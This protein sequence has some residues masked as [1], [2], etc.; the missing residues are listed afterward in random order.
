MRLLINGYVPLKVIKSSIFRH[1]FSSE[2]KKEIS[3][4]LDYHLFGNEGT[5]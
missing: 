1:W 4:N 3:V 2:L 5:L